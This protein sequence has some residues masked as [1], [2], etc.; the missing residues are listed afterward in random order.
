[1]SRASDAE[2]VQSRPQPKSQAFGLNEKFKGHFP[3][4]TEREREIDIYIYIYI[5]R[6]MYI[7]I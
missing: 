5:E 1:M 2:L 6:Y 7:C 3:P 4:S